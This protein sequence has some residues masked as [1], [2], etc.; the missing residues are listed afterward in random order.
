MKARS[1]TWS[2]VLW[3]FCWS[4][5][6]NAQNSNPPRPSNADSKRSDSAAQ[7]REPDVVYVPTPM[8]LV[9]AMLKVTKAGNGDVVYDL[10]SGDGRI[11]I[12]AVEK[13][14]VAR[15]VGIDINPERIRE[16]RENAKKAGV[17]AR[18][19]FSNEDL[20]E[21]K[22]SDASIVT[23]YLL[24]ALNLKLLPKLL[25]ELKP[26]TRV[27]SHAFDMGSWKPQQTLNIDGRQVYFW[28]IPQKGTPEYNAAMA[29]ARKSSANRCMDYN[30]CLA[31]TVAALAAAS[32]SAR[33]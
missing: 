6:V 18:V 29:A 2:L 19:R 31:I 16:A 24:T 13:F 23:L 3:F 30:R 22:I 14:N 33:P 11:P 4:A 17:E 10:G 8:D 25:Q 9:D 5:T 1:L 28:T 26:G 12:R 32:Q 20:F 7:L 21:T 27:V 15:A